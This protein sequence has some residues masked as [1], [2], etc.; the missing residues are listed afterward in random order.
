MQPDSERSRVAARSVLFADSEFQ[1]N[2][3]SEL[4]LFSGAAARAFDQAP[5][6]S[7]S[8]RDRA[9]HWLGSS[10]L[11]GGL[12]DT[13]TD[14]PRHQ[15]AHRLRPSSSGSVASYLVARAPLRAATMQLGLRQPQQ[16]RWPGA[17]S[18]QCNAQESVSSPPRPSAKLHPSDRSNAMKASSATNRR[19]KPFSGQLPRAATVLQPA[20]GPRVRGGVPVLTV[21]LARSPVSNGTFCRFEP[22]SCSLPMRYS[23]WA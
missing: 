6:V 12:S 19:Q 17:L 3:E 8:D 18:R 15:L 16:P 4:H 23:S 21:S 5:P 10:G 7:V 13:V 9:P 22:A 14:R 20:S 1:L 2:R 11:P